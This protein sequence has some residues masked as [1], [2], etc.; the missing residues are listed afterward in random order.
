MKY[1]KNNCLYL[2]SSDKDVK[3]DLYKILR[4]VQVCFPLDYERMEKIYKDVEIDQE[5]K[6]V[7]N[8]NQDNK[9]IYKS[10]LLPND[11]YQI[12]QEII[13]Y[14]KEY[15]TKK[16]KICLNG[17]NKITKFKLINK[18]PNAYA[19]QI[20]ELDKKLHRWSEFIVENKKGINLHDI[21]ISVYKLKRSK[22]TLNE[23]MYKI[24]EFYL[25][26]YGNDHEVTMVITF[27]SGLDE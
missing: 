19:S 14:V 24:N 11:D 10:E 2:G 6:Y 22:F 20:T 1:I 4:N 16:L 18:Y 9:Y 17:K 25:L 3:N 12:L 21:I 5:N 8:L 27:I 23:Y 13:E 26:N 15:G 7:N